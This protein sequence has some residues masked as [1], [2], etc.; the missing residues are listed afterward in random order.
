MHAYDQ[1]TNRFE[2]EI[3]LDYYFPEHAGVPAAEAIPAF[4]S[5]IPY[6][7]D[8]VRVGSCGWDDGACNANAVRGKPYCVGHM[9]KLAKQQE[10]ASA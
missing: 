9:R 5:G 10:V 1:T 7:G 6:K 3:P 8:E 2:N 4:P